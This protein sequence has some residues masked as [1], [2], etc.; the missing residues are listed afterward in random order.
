[1]TTENAPVTPLAAVALLIPCFNAGDRVA[2]VVRRAAEVA[3]HTFVIDDGST[4]GCTQ[5]LEGPGVQVLRH[6]TN[7]GKGHALLTGFRTALEQTGAECVAA[8]DADGQHDPGDLPQLYA[9]F[10]QQ[11][12]DLLIGARGLAHRGVPWASR[13]GNRV[14]ATVTRR[15]LPGCPSDTQSG[16]R[17]HRRSFLQAVLPRIHPGRYETEME[18]LVHA[19]R[20][21]YRVAEHPIATRYEPG[22]ASSHFRKVRDSWRIYRRLGIALLTR[23]APRAS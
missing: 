1:M 11:G 19:L 21:G 12:A 20:G 14:T 3:A 23:T 17:L 10:E 6:E 7:R 8:L 5:G 4:D 22:N 2:P 16:Y 9:A 13:L 15:L 18:L